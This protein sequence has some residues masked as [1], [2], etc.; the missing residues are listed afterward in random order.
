[1]LKKVLFAS[2]VLAVGTEAIYIKEGAAHAH[3]KNNNFA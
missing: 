2:S 3:G 1:M